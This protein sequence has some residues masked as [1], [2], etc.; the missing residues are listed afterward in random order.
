MEAGFLTMG[1]T[2]KNLVNEVYISFG[3]LNHFDCTFQGRIWERL[4]TYINGCTN[5]TFLERVFVIICSWIKTKC[6]A[7]RACDMLG[8]A[9]LDN[10]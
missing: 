7:I 3:C 1:L 4:L 8:W 10:F 6:N 2:D 5:K 9:S